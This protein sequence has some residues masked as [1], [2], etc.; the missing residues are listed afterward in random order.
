MS[1]S[2]CF[3][4]LLPICADL[5]HSQQ[6][7]SAI[8][9]PKYVFQARRCDSAMQLVLNGLSASTASVKAYLL[10]SID[11]LKKRSQKSLDERCACAA[12]MAKASCPLLH[13]GVGIDQLPDD[14]CHLP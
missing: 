2:H 3:K 14:G 8:N 12:L 1:S 4:D 9:T 6:A 10:L 5:A 13:V 7:I 11:N